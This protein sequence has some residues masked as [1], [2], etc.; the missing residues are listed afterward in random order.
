M[1]DGDPHLKPVLL[2]ASEL[3]IPVIVL[4]EYRYG[5]ADSHFRSRYEQWCRI[6]DT[7]DQLVT[8]TPKGAFRRTGT[9][10]FVA[11]ETA[12][13]STAPGVLR[14]QRPAPL[15]PPAVLRLALE[16]PSSVEP[17]HDGTYNKLRARSFLGISN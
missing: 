6:G 7:T 15:G 2:R 11:A 10:Y 13:L 8:A 14:L 12:P 1:A 4:G 5:I 3:T 17:R 9:R 16:P